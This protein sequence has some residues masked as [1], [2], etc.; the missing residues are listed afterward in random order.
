M[1]VVATSGTGYILGTGNGAVD[2]AGL[3]Y[4]CAGTMMIAASANS[5]NQ[6]FEIS[7]DAKMKRTMRRPLPSGRMSVPHAVAWATIAGASG[8]CLLATKVIAD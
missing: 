6:I 4:T 1:L 7:N 2:L 8:A 5:L 3:C